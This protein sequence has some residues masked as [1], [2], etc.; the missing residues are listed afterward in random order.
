MEKSL[1]TNKLLNK[2]NIN[3]LTSNW[4]CI[5]TLMT[6]GFA[7]SI[8]NKLIE[9]DYKFKIDINKNPKIEIYK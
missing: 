5:C 8:I 1:T 6:L 3:V 9:K 2:G 7:Y 4:K